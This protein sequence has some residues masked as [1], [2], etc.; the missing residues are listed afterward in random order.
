MCI[1][2]APGGP[3][4]ADP[5]HVSSSSVSDK[6]QPVAEMFSENKSHVTGRTAAG[7]HSLLEDLS[8]LS[9]DHTASHKELFIWVRQRDGESVC[10]L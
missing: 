5:F 4:T 7:R 3:N 2:E 10:P 8:L 9:A 1:I 6:E